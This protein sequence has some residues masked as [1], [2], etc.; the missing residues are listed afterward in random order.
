MKLILLTEVKG[1]GKKGQLIEASTG[2]AK[3]FLI[4]KKLAVEATAANVAELEFKKRHEEKR[5]VEAIEDAK[6][7]KK[8][9]EGKHIVI[10]VKS[11]ENG[12]LFGSVTSKEIA[13]ELERQG[14]IVLDRKRILLAEPIKATG[15]KEV[16]AKL[17]AEVTAKLTLEII[18]DEN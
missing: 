18:A 6:E 5:R 4:P 7:F 15:I 2:Y 1:T 12:K 14:R 11:G 9:L 3:N 10:K 16:E 13:A 8:E 17:H